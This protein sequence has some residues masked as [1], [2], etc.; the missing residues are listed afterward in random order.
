MLMLS[1]AAACNDLVCEHVREC[2]PWGLWSII[3]F[4][5]QTEPCSNKIMVVCL[6]ANIRVSFLLGAISRNRWLKMLGE[7]CQAEGMACNIDATGR[8]F[9][10][11]S[12]RKCGFHV[13]ALFAAGGWG[14]ASIWSPL[15]RVLWTF[16]QQEHATLDSSRA[17]SAS[18][19]Q[20]RFSR[21]PEAYQRGAVFYHSPF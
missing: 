21:C 12:E 11:L 20:S 6:L 13:R 15:F 14:V 5:P 10:G 19:G 9:P 7:V 18:G 4:H 3:Y 8:L 1:G 16:V 17:S 2:A